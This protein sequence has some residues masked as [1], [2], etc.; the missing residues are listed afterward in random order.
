MPAAL[1]LPLF[2][3]GAEIAAG[4]FAVAAAGFAIRLATT[5]A[6]ASLLQKD[7]QPTVGSGT[8]GGEVQL[9]PDT[10]N[11][12]PVAYGDCYVSP[13]ITDAI[14]S[15]DQQ[16]M[17]YVLTFSETTDTGNVH[18]EEVW[19]D[20]KLLLFDG[21]AGGNPNEILG[22]WTRPKKNSTIGGTIE[23]GPAGKVAMYF[24]KNGSL[25]TGTQHRAYDN[26]AGFD[27]IT[28]NLQS[29]GIDAISLLQDTRIPDQ[30]KWIANDKMSNTVFAVI[31]LN[32]D[33][34]N[35][36]NGLGN[37]QAKISNTLN[38]PGDVIKD[39]LLNTRY[40]A[41]VPLA[42][43]NTDSLTALNTISAAALSI[44]DTTNQSV[45]NTFTYQI[46][47]LVDTTKDCLSILNEMT[48]ACDSWLQWDERQ[49]KWGVI[50]NISLLQSGQ[51]VE[52]MTVINSNNIIGGINV[53]PTD[54]KSSANKITVSFPNP[55]IIGQVDYRYYWLESQ[56]K[57]PNEPE[58]NIQVALGFVNDPIQAT[59]LGYR[60]LWMA[61]EDMIINFTM[62]YSGIHLNAGDVV[63]IN[64]EWYGWGPGTYNGLTA[65]GKPFRITQIKE[66]KDASGFLSVQIVAMSYN[67]SIYTTMN[68]HYF[69]PD[70]F[71]LLTN[72]N[73]IS[74]PNAPIY[75]TDLSNTSTGVFII[76]GD[77]PDYGN[78][79][80]MEFWYS[81]TTST[82]NANNYTLY[83]TQYYGNGNLYPHK[84]TAGTR[85]FEQ[86]QLQNFATST[87]W[88]VTRAEGPNSFSPFSDPSQPIKWSSTGTVIIGQQVLDSSIS[89]SKVV[90]P[91]ANTQPS[92]SGGFFDTLG[93]IAGVGL[94]LAAGYG[95]YNSGALG[96][97]TDYLQDLLGGGNGNDKGPSPE[98]KSPTSKIL[99]ADNQGNEKPAAEAQ[100]GDTQIAQLDT[101]PQPG[102][103]AENSNFNGYDVAQNVPDGGSSGDMEG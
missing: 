81:A 24:Y 84:D 90:P 26:S 80:G 19:F 64:H 36:V 38:A 3:T 101:T 55:D 93:P 22:W 50:P 51:T 33:S 20:G 47:G 87:Y 46:N 77:I 62:D 95:L 2:F 52:T 102:P 88:W 31:R 25:I 98:I 18:F 92:Q 91:A 97:A 41:G 48:D 89:G 23:T 6:I 7:Q 37:I 27:H 43:I 68:P 14:I 35:G 66:S 8:S 54:L 56:F 10:D 13:I 61:R 40:G 103:P 99:Y 83:T 12:L 71:G 63:A 57:S 34:N 28:D 60:K 15:T 1:I 49:G 79:T 39:F 42:S 29:T 58:N 70:E 59:Y 72:T 53:T 44:T 76:Q 73:F 17:W 96:K 5:F 4:G 100:P 86:I 82:F 32:Y 85:Y 65:P 11:K 94:A 78:V 75:R 74:K 16:T 9:G 67:D 21:N 30:L 45:S 69:T